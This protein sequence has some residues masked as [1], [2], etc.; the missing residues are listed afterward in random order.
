MPSVPQPLL[1]VLVQILAVQ[2]MHAIGIKLGAKLDVLHA[3]WIW[4][5]R[6]VALAIYAAQKVMV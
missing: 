2:V 1:V 6:D 5:R 4:L 3:S